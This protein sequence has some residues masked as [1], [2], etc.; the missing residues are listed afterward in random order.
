MFVE[1]HGQVLIMEIMM[2]MEICR[3]F[4]ILEQDNQELIRN[5][6]DAVKMAVTVR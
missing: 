6:V 5:A 4:L 1:L 2:K 3:L